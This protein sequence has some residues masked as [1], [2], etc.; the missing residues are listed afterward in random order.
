M[1]GAHHP[2]KTRYKNAAPDSISLGTGRLLPRGL[3][4]PRKVEEGGAGR[5]YPGPLHL[6]L[7]CMY[8]I[9]KHGEANHRQNQLA[10]SARYPGRAWEVRGDPTAPGTH[11]NCLPAQVSAWPGGGGQH[12]S[13]TCGL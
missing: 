4:P 12:I 11:H 7:T 13:L 9:C 1:L 5:I 3:R 8:R 6:P 2:P 10:V